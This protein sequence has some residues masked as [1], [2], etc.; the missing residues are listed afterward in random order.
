[1]QTCFLRHCCV[2]RKWDTT[3][4]PR[5]AR[6]ISKHTKGVYS[7]PDKSAIRHL[8]LDASVRGLDPAQLSG[9]RDAR[10][11]ESRRRSPFPGRPR[12]AVS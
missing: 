7:T 11:Q 10:W 6:R 3:P 12:Y 2:G 9:L 1:M 5:E 8:A 4:A